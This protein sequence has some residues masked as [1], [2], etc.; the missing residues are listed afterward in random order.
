MPWIRPIQWKDEPLLVLDAETIGL[1]PPSRGGICEVGLLIMQH[2]EV[3]ESQVL[4]IH[5]EHPIPEEASKI[6]GIY[7]KDVKGCPTIDHYAEGICSAVDSVDI[8]VAYNAPFDIGYLGNCPGFSEAMRSKGLLD[9]LTVVRLP[10]VGK[11][12]SGQG[13]HK[14]ANVAVRLNLV[15]DTD[16]GGWHGA[17]V[18]AIFAGRILWHLRDHLP[19]D[20]DEAMEYLGAA[21]RAQNDNFASWKASLAAKDETREVIRAEARECCEAGVDFHETRE[22]AREFNGERDKHARLIDGEV[23]QIIASVYERRG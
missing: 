7:D 22:I 5:P 18:D 23:D 21:K 15:R 12:W 4:R 14:L 13:R 2:G 11:Y 19:D 6:H 8:V 9:P 1:K 20:L 3:V 17:Y 16:D 10:E